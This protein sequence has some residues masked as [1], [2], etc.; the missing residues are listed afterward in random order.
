[1]LNI[2]LEIAK[3]CHSWTSIQKKGKIL[4]IPIWQG[5]V[6][7]AKKRQDLYVLNWKSPHDVMLFMCQSRQQYFAEF[8][9]AWFLNAGLC[10]NTIC[11]SGSSQGIRVSVPSLFSISPESISNT[12]MFIYFVYCI[13]IIMHL[14]QGVVIEQP[15]YKHRPRL[16]MT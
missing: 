9:F 11:Y 1:M 4:Q 5:G 15:L 14:L 16:S 2:F 3:C 10:K 13:T 6:H 8:K 12:R 7:E